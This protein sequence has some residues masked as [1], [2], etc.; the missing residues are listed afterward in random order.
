MRGKQQT[1]SSFLLGATLALILTSVPAKAEPDD[2]RRRQQQEAE[3]QGNQV[4]D[5]QLQP[6]KMMHDMQKMQHMQNAEKARQQQ[7]YGTAEKEEQMAMM[8]QMKSQQLQQQIN[9]NKD[10]ARQ[11][12]QGV[13]KLSKNDDP[14]G[15]Q[16][17]YNP[18]VVSVRK[19]DVPPS[20]GSPAP[21]AT[22]QASLPAPPA[23]LADLTSFDRNSVPQLA[24]PP[25]RLDPPPAGNT[26]E[27]APAD[28]LLGDLEKLDRAAV[29]YDDSSK[30][31]SSRNSGAEPGPQNRLLTAASTASP[32]S[33]SSVGSSSASA[34]GAETDIWGR[35][36]ARPEEAS[37]PVKT[38]VRSPASLSSSGAS[39]AATGALGALDKDFFDPCPSPKEWKKMSPEQR[40]GVRESCQ[41]LAKT[42]EKEA[43]DLK[44]KTKGKKKEA[45]T[46]CREWQGEK[47]A[48]EASKPKTVQQAKK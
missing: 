26:T 33:S 16:K 28:R 43:Q 40:G 12:Q 1:I 5:Q 27:G 34:G 42:C 6:Q 21:Q 10:T 32:A 9:A 2:D 36:A 47:K 11:N 14:A 20:P 44:K 15:K 37:A 29:V 3:R 46:A 35:P 17:G 31:P 23:Q 4:T 8:E 19:G 13:D 25:P 24:E 30:A 22:P 39:E 38:T 41:K 18:D 48:S 7:D 45:T